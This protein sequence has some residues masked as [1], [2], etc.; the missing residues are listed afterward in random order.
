[1]NSAVEAGKANGGKVRTRLE[2]RLDTVRQG[3]SEES[4][5]DYD[6]CLHNIKRDMLKL[7]DTYSKRIKLLRVLFVMGVLCAAGALLMLMTSTRIRFG[8]ALGAGGALCAV[9]YILLIMQQNALGQVLGFDDEHFAGRIW[10]DYINGI[11]A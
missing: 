5:I 6:R 4:A 9:S 8:L 7:M 10:F 1:M 11:R 2:A 3:D